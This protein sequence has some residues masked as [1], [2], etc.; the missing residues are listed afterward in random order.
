[1]TALVWFPVV[2]VKKT[3]VGFT[4]SLL[5]C[6]ALEL[7]ESAQPTHAQHGKDQLKQVIE[8]Q[9]WQGGHTRVEHHECPIGD[10]VSDESPCNAHAAHP[11]DPRAPAGDE[12]RTVRGLLSVDLKLRHHGVVGRTHDVG[13]ELFFGAGA[14]VAVRDKVE[15][16]IDRGT[17]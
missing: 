12:D 16:P 17:E 5:S 1:M 9:V 2:V 14:L 7:F 6:N 4:Y 15:H 8:F 3:M 11:T 10:E 13:F